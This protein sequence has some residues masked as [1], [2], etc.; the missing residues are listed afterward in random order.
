MNGYGSRESAETSKSFRKFSRD[1]LLTLELA[2]ELT[3][4][5][6]ECAVYMSALVFMSESM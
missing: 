4:T 3:C 6:L 5:A 2:L 1:P